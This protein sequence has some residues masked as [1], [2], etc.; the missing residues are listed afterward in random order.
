MPKD[1]P[2]RSSRALGARHDAPPF[3]TEPDMPLG[4]TLTLQRLSLAET[5]KA[6]QARLDAAR[7]KVKQAIASLGERT[8]PPAPREPPLRRL[9]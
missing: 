2:S 7:L 8:A 6:E 1:E 3:D 5:L 9:P 4:V